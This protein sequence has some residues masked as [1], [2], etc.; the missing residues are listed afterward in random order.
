MPFEEIRNKLKTFTLVDDNR[1]K[2][3]FD[4]VTETRHIYG[5]MAEIGVYKGGSSYLI[6]KTD[7]HRLLYSCDSFEG[8]PEVDSTIDTHKK[9]DFNDVDFEKVKQLLNLP[10]VKII[11]GF[12][13]NKE[14]HK[15]MYDKQYSF[16]HIDVDLYKPTLDCL[17]FFYPR[18]LPGA[19]LVS[20]DYLW[21]GCAGVKK[22]F[23]EFMLDKPEK[24]IDTECK[25][26]YFVKQL[27]FKR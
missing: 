2:I 11:K 21:K 26:C 25:S 10:N 24:L 15:D 16:V 27:H 18:L 22:A 5:V 4:K 6:A 13:P 1:L 20:D 7:T 9:G 8:L 12:F 3:I 14:L 17:N 23:D 19:I